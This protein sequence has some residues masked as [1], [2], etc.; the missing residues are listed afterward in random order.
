MPYTPGLE[1]QSC[2]TL[3]RL[4]W[5]AGAPMTKTMQEVFRLLPFLM[6]GSK[7]CAE[8]RDSSMCTE[9][10]FDLANREKLGFEFFEDLVNIDVMADRIAP[11]NRNS[12][13][14]D[15]GK[16]GGKKRRGETTVPYREREKSCMQVK[17]KRVS[18]ESVYTEFGYFPVEEE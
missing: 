7:V 15:R 5:A 4:S 12:R 1:L 16:S 13:E 14:R 6:D 18:E 10:L 3:R 11:G 17:K 2:V 8:C 9:C